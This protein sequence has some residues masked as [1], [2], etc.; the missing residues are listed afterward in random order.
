VGT[1]SFLDSGLV[2]S[3]LETS[4]DTEIAR[5]GGLGIGGLGSAS[6]MYLEAT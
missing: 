4:E 5:N 3:P 1:P 6:L 2:W